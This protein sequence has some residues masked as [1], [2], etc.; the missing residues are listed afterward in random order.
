[1]LAARWR[2]RGIYS[3]RGDVLDLSQ[4]PMNCVGFSCLFSHGV[5][6][7]AGYDDV[8]C[9]GATMNSTKVEIFQQGAA[10][11][12]YPGAITSDTITFYW[13]R[14]VGFAT[15]RGRHIVFRLG[16]KH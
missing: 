10:A 8:F 3:T 7:L 1:M 9:P 16:E 14:W 13:K 2:R 15:T 5:D 6:G 4:V 11:G 12:A